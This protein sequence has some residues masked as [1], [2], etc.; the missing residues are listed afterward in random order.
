MRRHA[1]VGAGGGSV[2]ALL[3]PSEFRA[4]NCSEFYL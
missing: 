3:F 1:A 4:Q 2:A